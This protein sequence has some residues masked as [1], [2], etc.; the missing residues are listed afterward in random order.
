MHLRRSLAILLLLV[1]LPLASWKVYLPIMA[2]AQESG[3]AGV[4]LWLEDPS[5]CQVLDLLDVAWYYTGPTDCP[6]H[7]YVA[8]IAK[9]WSFTWVE[10]TPYTL[11][12]NEPEYSPSSMDD[13]VSAFVP[14]VE[15][16]P[17]T[18]WVGPCPAY[19]LVWF[20]MFWE[21]FEQVAGY[22]MPRERIRM[23]FHCYDSAANCAVRLERAKAL[24]YPVWVTEFGRPLGL[25]MT[26]RQQAED[27]AQMVA[28][29]E[30]DPQVE[31]YAYWPA[32]Y[33]PGWEVPG[34]TWMPL[35]VPLVG[36]DQE[37]VVGYTLTLVGQTYAGQ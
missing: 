21:R 31:R 19:D 12:W 33:R 8:Y 23:C 7:E 20:T 14:Y 10:A 9:E 4:G 25:D 1:M 37:T 6:G 17:D 36:W 24:G 29:L 15:Q 28:I 3:K 11:L 26:L 32:T 2:T 30:S 35:A 22:E 34:L 13:M 27:T 16:Y 18:V 5:A